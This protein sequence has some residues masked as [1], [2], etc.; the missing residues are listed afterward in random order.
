[1][2]KFQS[3]MARET[4][5]SRPSSRRDD[6][7]GVAQHAANGIRIV[8]RTALGQRR[9]FEHVDELT[10]FQVRLQ[11]IRCV[12]DCLADQKKRIVVQFANRTSRPPPGSSFNSARAWS[13][14]CQTPVAASKTSSL[15]GPTIVVATSA[16]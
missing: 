8:D 15:P 3:V 1:M 7:V 4:P 10:R 2:Q 16:L 12:H 11:L 9:T 6:Q 5:T 14:G 13:A